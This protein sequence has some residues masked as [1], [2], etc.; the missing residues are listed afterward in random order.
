MSQAF[1]QRHGRF[2]RLSNGGQ[3]A[4]RTRSFAHGLTFSAEPLRAGELFLIE[5]TQTESGWSGDLRVGITQVRP[6][7]MP[8]LP[9]FAVPDLS[10]R[11]GRSYVRTVGGVASSASSS[12][13][14]S[15]GAAAASSS[16]PSP[17]L[18]RRGNLVQSPCGLVHYPNLVP[19]HTLKRGTDTDKGA[20]IGVYFMPEQGQGRDAEPDLARLHLVVNGVDM[21]PD[22]QPFPYKDRDHFA[23]VDVYGK[24]K[25]VRIIP[26]CQRLPPLTDL[27]LLAILRM[28]SNDEICRLPLPERIKLYI[29]AG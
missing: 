17:L 5:V 10:S 18:R 26:T 24:T 8:R 23:V 20:R 16:S 27:C 9:K 25:Q 1:H 4:T 14:A 2:I 28:Y 11:F 29:T 19:R 3:T 6:D 22:E 15:P 7:A 21:G 13:A 12:S